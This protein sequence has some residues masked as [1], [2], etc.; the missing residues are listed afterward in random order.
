MMDQ[1][2][3][4]QVRQRV[5]ALS[6]P[7]AVELWNGVRVEHGHP[8]KVHVRLH[9]LAALKALA[10]PSLGA[11]AHAYV[12]GD[13]DLD[14]DIRDI[15]SLG[16]TLCN[17]GECKPD[18]GSTGWKWW[19]HIRAKDRKNIQYHY[20]ISNAFY[21]LWLDARRV[22]SC[23]YFR[24]SG[25]SLEAA[26]EAKLDHI[27]RKLN[28][29]PGERLLDIGCGWGGLIMHAAGKYGVQAT[30]ITLSEQQHAYVNE[31][32][33][34][35]GLEKNVEVRLMDYRDVPEEAVYDKV[36]S[37]GMFEHVG[38]ANLT[39][40]FSRI[41]QL[42]KPGGLV[43]NHGITS[44]ALDSQ[45]L[46][47]GI[48]EFI[49]DYVFPGGELVHISDVM[50]AASGSGLECLDAENLR[51]HYGQT[52]WHWVTR[53]EHHADEARR[54]VGEQKYRIWRIYMAGS[55]HAFDHGWMEL[56]QVLAG[57]GVGPG[58]YPF[59]RAYMYP[60]NDASPTM[61]NA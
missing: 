4:T 47:S 59:N 19:R 31:Q 9:N 21:A 11:L 34:A 39:A 32:I 41:N 22:Y 14:G 54:L 8:P 48:S 53:M 7:L 26:Q 10:R 17:A 20:D 24:D 29:R 12:E 52:L 55:A 58:L 13:L 18:T 42:L 6:L 50:R 46:G 40:Y 43:L 49:E 51:P 15:L 60:C 1:M 44:A 35:R 33:E 25:M 56:W 45:G 23:A 5:Q 3:I 30:G 2:Q 27:C 36:A 38:R 37:V 28:L 57:K 61:S 16:D